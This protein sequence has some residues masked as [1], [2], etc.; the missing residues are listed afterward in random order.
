MQWDHTDHAGFSQTEPWLRIAKDF[1]QVNVAQQSVDTSSLLSFYKRLIELR[2]SEKAL[3]QGLYT[4]VHATGNILTYIREADDQ[5][6]LI[7]LNMGNK[8]TRFT[9]TN[10]VI[11]GKVELSTH[12]ESEGKQI[13]DTLALKANEGQIIRLA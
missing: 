7:A 1:K 4:P 6:L 13:K 2:K 3:H 5:K 12:P 8:S 11:K 9:P 10:I